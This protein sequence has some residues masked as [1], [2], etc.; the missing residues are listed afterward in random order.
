MF[1]K[2]A[3]ILVLNFGCTFFFHRE[4]KYI[5][6]DLYISEREREGGRGRRGRGRERGREEI[7]G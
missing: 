6:I 4:G 7:R 2:V 3:V 1:Y 5:Y